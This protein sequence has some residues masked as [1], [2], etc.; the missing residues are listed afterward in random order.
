MG[1][2]QKI[3][4]GGNMIKRMRIETNRLVVKP[5]TKNDLLESFQLM[6]NKELFKYMDMEVMSF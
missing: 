5:Y 1:E 4:R 3:V 6:Q 2:E